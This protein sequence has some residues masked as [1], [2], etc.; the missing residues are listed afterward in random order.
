M[1]KE[2]KANAFGKEIPEIKDIFRDEKVKR[3][4]EQRL[5]RVLNYLEIGSADKVVDRVIEAAQNYK[6]VSEYE[7]NIHKLF[8]QRRIIQRIPIKLSSR[9][10]LIFSQ[11]AK[12]L[13]GHHVLDLGCGDGKV[14]E[15]IEK[16]GRRVVLADV[17]ENGNI[18]NINL[19]FVLIK[20]TDK[21]PFDDDLFDTTLLLTVLHHSD[22]PRKVIAETKRVTRK[23]GR[24]I[25]IESVY[26]IPGYS[27]NLSEEQQRLA[28]VFFDHFYN[29][30]IHYSEFEENKVNVPF[31][32]QTP[33]AW[34]KFFEENGLRQKK[35][36]SLGFDQ[37]T[38]P[39]YHTMHVLEVTK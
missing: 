9:A 13:T 11:V 25:V 4:I 32:F 17:Y 24:I 12:D 3:Y 33:K 6:R 7:Y 1:V 5:T 30:I 8:D 37:P 35:V 28:N 34:K 29:R 20:Q 10:Q 14:G 15:L 39:E 22:K 18:S 21:L 36:V 16:Q 27:K 19:P 26:G 38:V 2:M 23:G 31:N